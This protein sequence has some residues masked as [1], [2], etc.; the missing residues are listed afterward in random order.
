[1][2]KL[3]FLCYTSYMKTRFQPQFDLKQ[4]AESGQCF[5]MT[6]CAPGVW[7]VVSGE[8]YLEIS[9]DASTFYFD[10]PDKDYPFWVNYFDLDTDYGAYIASVRKRDSYL[11]A[12]AGAGS[13]IRILRQDVWEMIVTFIISQQRT[14]P[15]IREAVEALSCRYG[16]RRETVL[17]GGAGRVY[18]TFPTPEQLGRASLD[19]LKALKL[20]YRAAYISR[21][22]EDALQGRLD[23]DKLSG[24]DY[25][26][27]FEYLTGFYGIGAKIANC[28]CLFGLHHIDAFPVDTWISQILMEHYYPKNPKKYR[29]LPKS[30]LYEALIRDYFG[31]YQGYAGVMQQYIFYYERKEAGNGTGRRTV[32]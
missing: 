30:R 22:C 10:C 1:M 31:G 3:F 27:A 26:R 14:I 5:R 4:T 29:A 20:G 24:M 17:S 23:L 12:A 15:K 13:G 25:E 11:T 9:Q 2:C 19:E 18:Y 28:V 8:R 6:P 7:S 21:I 16:V 32:K